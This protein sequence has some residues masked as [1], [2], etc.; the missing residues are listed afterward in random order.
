MYRPLCLLTFTLLYCGALR[1]ASDHEPPPAASCTP[2]SVETVTY[3]QQQQ[4]EQ[5][6]RDFFKARE[7]REWQTVKRLSTPTYYEH[8]EQVIKEGGIAGYDDL[9]LRAEGTLKVTK[10]SGYY[11]DG[12]SPVDYPLSRE[13]PTLQLMID[14]DFI[15]PDGHTLA[16]RYFTRGEKGKDGDY[17]IPGLATSP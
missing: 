2:E 6:I 3:P 9:A 10:I 12:C 8:M 1:A 15:K 7:E 16:V 5:R 14:F 11:F 4:F 17:L 13:H